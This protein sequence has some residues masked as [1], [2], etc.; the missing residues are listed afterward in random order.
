MNHNLFAVFSF[1]DRGG[2]AVFN[3]YPAAE[4]MNAMISVPDQGEGDVAKPNTV[5]QIRVNPSTYEIHGQGVE[6]DLEIRQ[7]K[8]ELRKKDYDETG[9]L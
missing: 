8:W 2:N 7:Q 5:G 1:I 6:P 4:Y 3:L 9:T